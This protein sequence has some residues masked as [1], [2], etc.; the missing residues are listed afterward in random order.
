MGDPIEVNATSAVLVEGAPK[1]TQP[2]TLIASKSWLGHAEPAAGTVGTLHGMYAMAQRLAL[3]NA[4]LISLNPYVEKVLSSCPGALSR[5]WCL[6]RQAGP[7]PAVSLGKTVVRTSGISGFAF[8]VG[9]AGGFNSL[10]L[11]ACRKLAGC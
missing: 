6:P 11:C 1:R 3:P 5:A 9:S 4:H 7:V 10:S 8:Q 2:L